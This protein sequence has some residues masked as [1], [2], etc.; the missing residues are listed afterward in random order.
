[1]ANNDSVSKNI[2]IYLNT[3][4]ESD[5][6]SYYSKPEEKEDNRKANANILGYNNYKTKPNPKPVN[7]LRSVVIE[8]T[9]HGIIFNILLIIYFNSLLFSSFLFKEFHPF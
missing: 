9:N 1:L 4:K 5:S 2:E 7:P 8:I 3:N 6:F